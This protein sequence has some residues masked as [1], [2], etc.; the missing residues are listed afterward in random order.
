MLLPIIEYIPICVAKP[1]IP[2]FLHYIEK[3]K[4]ITITTDVYYSRVLFSYL[5]ESYKFLLRSS[6]Q[7][8][9]GIKE[10]KN[11]SFICENVF[12]LP[13]SNNQ[14][15][16]NLS[17]NLLLALYKILKKRNEYHKRCV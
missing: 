11:H 6:L 3:F 1:E 5:P 4:Q 10:K 13:I 2:I 17:P 8:V 14:T 16:K 9:R 12:P 7:N 15:V